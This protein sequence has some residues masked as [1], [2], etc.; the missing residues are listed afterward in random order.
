MNDAGIRERCCRFGERD[1]LV[2]I[3][4]EPAETP[5][6]GVVIVTAGL[7]PKFGPF[8]LYTQLAR[9]LAH[10][11]L[12]VLRFDLG[13]IGDSIPAHGALPLAKRTEI[14]IRAAV[15]HL[16]EGLAPGQLILGGLCSGAEDAFRYAELDARVTGVFLLDPFGF[17]TF[18]WIWRDYL[19]RAARRGL[20]RLGYL[21]TFRSGDADQSTLIHYEQM[22]YEECSRI[23]RALIARKVGMHFLYTGGMRATF[24]HRR[25]F[26]AMFRGIAFT[27]A[28]TFDYFPQL[29]HTQAL[30]ADRQLVVQSVARG[31][32]SMLALTA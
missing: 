1:R 32:S 23:M 12:R 27:Q 30:E 14:E 7:T 20:A 2:G 28:P 8:Q 13:G 17:R 21:P 22:G 16:L 25:Q 6:A 15:E 5:R 29:R 4:T 9:R 18:G 10:D 19:I 31:L 11:G 3:I 24:N 26:G